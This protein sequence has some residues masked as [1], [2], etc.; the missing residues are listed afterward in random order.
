MS[1]A[2]N[3]SIAT[4][5]IGLPATVAH[6]Q[7]E[8]DTVMQQLPHGNFYDVG[9]THSSFTRGSPSMLRIPLSES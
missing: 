6:G 1:T 2:G 8:E 5:D 9:R 7:H 4:G 3:T